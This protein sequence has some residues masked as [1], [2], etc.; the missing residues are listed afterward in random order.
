MS[1]S[2]DTTRAADLYW[3]AFLLTGRPDISIDIAVDS[4]VMQGGGTSYFTA[5]LR[6]WSRRIAIAKALV[7]VR[8]EL[9][10]SAARTARAR[11]RTDAAAPGNWTLPPNTTSSQIEAALLAID[12]FPRA[13]VLLLMF[14]RVHIADAATLLEADAALVRKGL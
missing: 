14:E 9:A 1:Q 7:E 6:S 8:D 2:E 5:W 12:A 11:V 10:E 3:I 4:T 13:A